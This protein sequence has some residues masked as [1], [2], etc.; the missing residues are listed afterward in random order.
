[1]LQNG[2]SR[3]VVNEKNQK[4]LDIATLKNFLE[5]ADVLRYDPV[6]VPICLAAKHG[7]WNV[8]HALLL[9]GLFFI[10]IAI[11]TIFKLFFFLPLKNYTNIVCKTNK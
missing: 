1:L 8:L 3:E 10:I 5:C 11:I 6:H 2:A 4:P 9:Q 7:D